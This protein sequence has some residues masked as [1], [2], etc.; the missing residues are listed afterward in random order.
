MIN[1]LKV[2]THF[3]LG[4][5]LDSSKEKCLSKIRYLWAAICLLKNRTLIGYSIRK[6][7]NKIIQTFT[8]RCLPI[9]V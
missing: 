7:W 2:K 5:F 3:V 1:M 8:G 9:M 6:L 4:E